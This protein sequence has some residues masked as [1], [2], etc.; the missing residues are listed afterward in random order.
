[1]VV[2][3]DVVVVVL[4][5][6]VD[7]VV[8]VL[9]VVVVVPVQRDGAKIAP[10][11]STTLRV[12]NTTSIPLPGALPFVGGEWSQALFLA[13][14]ALAELFTRSALV[15]QLKVLSPRPPSVPPP[16]SGFELPSTETPTEF[17]VIVFPSISAV[18]LP[19]VKIPFV[20]FVIMLSAIKGSAVSIT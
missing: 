20:L 2:V 1:V 9:V 14:M 7:V 3:V 4:V 19:L 5:V 12:P 10:A 18:A 17:P 13:L 15:L 8:D 16:R 6:C 11:V